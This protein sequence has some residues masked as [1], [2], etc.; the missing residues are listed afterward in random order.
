MLTILVTL[1]IPHRIVSI[2]SQGHIHIL[3]SQEPKNE[4][5]LPTNDSAWVSP[6]KTTSKEA[7]DISPV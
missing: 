6:I 2:G 3:T 1:L 5:S 4:D 7:T